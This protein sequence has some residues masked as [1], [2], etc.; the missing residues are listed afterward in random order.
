MAKYINPIDN[1]IFDVSIAPASYAAAETNAVGGASQVATA[2][3]G[4][5]FAT[6]QDVSAPFTFSSGSSRS[7]YVYY[8]FNINFIPQGAEILNVF[9]EVR[10]HTSVTV[11]VILGYFTKDYGID[12]RT[13]VNMS[14]SQNVPNNKN[15]TINIQTDSGWD[16][17]KLSR[18]NLRFG[19][20]TSG[21]MYF[22]GCTLTIRYQYNGIIYEVN[23]ENLSNLIGQIYPDGLTD[24]YPEDYIHPY[25][26]SMVGDSIT[27]ISVYD[28]AIDS[29]TDV[30]TLSDVTGQ[31]SEYI[32]TPG[33]SSTTNT[34]VDATAT[35]LVYISDGTTYEADNDHHYRDPI[36]KGSN[37]TS[38]LSSNKYLFRRSSQSFD[39]Y[40]DYKFD[41]SDI[42]FTAK[43]PDVSA[44]NLPNIIVSDVSVSVKGRAQFVSNY[45]SIANVRLYSGDG[46]PKSESIE[47]GSKTDQVV[48]FNYPGKWTVQE[49]QN[50][51]VRFTFGISGGYVVGITWKVNYIIEPDYP[52]YWTYTLP[53]VHEDHDITVVDKYQG[54]RYNV[55]TVVYYK[56]AVEVSNTHRVIRAND[57]YN[58]TIYTTDIAH[59]EL[60]DNNVNKT[61][62]LTR[63]SPN[64]NAYIYTI[65]SVTRNHTIKIVETLNFAISAESLVEDVTITLSSEKVYEGDSFTITLSTSSLDPIYIRDN[66]TNITNSFSRISSNTYRATISNVQ[67]DHEIIV[68]ERA[69]HV[70]TGLSNSENLVISPE[71]YVSVLDGDS[72]TL[73]ITTGNVNTMMMFNGN[74]TMITVPKY[75]VP[76]SNIIL[77][78]NDV[79]VSDQLMDV[80]TNKYSYT[81]SDVDES[82]TVV[83]YELFVPE[84]EDPQYNYYSLSIS[85][86][87]AVTNPPT[88][89]VRVV[90]GTNAN[91]SI[92]PQE[93]V[94]IICSDN[95]EDIT[96]KFQKTFI[97]GVAVEADPSY[98]VENR[99]SYKFILNNNTGYYTSN[100]TGISNSQAVARLNVVLPVDCTVELEYINYAEEGADFGI[101]GK[102]DIPLSADSGA[103][104]DQNA[105]IICNSAVY[106]KPYEQTIEYD[107]SAGSHFIDIKFLKN[108]NIYH[109]NNDSL[110]WK[111][112]SIKA[113]TPYVYYNYLVEDIHED[114]S[115]VFVFGENAY[116]TV[117]S[118]GINSRLFPNGTMIKRSDENYTLTIIPNIELFKLILRDNGIEKSNDIVKIEAV[119]D[120]Q[121]IVNYIYTIKRI[122]DNHV[123]EVDCK[124]PYD[125][126]QKLNGEW[127]SISKIYKKINGEWVLI[128]N[129]D[130][131]FINDPNTVRIFKG[132]LDNGR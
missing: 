25:V 38:S 102:I 50:A 126:F 31:L 57:T 89:T 65:D 123:I 51:F 101:F 40:I 55:D 60:I 7:Y 85:S 48:T 12:G 88:G 100:N 94:I 24:V 35:G 13:W 46:V 130:D 58:L 73:I 115:L 111:V 63:L 72:Q 43:I 117:E 98:T 99:A 82:H 42:L 104:V 11:P 18:I 95:G 9:G 116:Y 110:Q 33:L 108:S 93:P 74:P 75:A 77:K 107:V 112:K 118:S 19:Q 5:N 114:H 54:R 97:D 79:D 39:S 106:N 8:T 52:K 53:S 71:G 132:F 56:N 92:I 122:S 64:A 67:E 14:T 22:Y 128:Y 121:T 68:Y 84:Y 29:S 21:T 34:A 61:S 66:G 103:Q 23:T 41:F 2:V 30:H 105:Q 16:R 81:I 37:G 113:K 109:L 3:N 15:T 120:K 1:D 83:V 80:T 76:K 91:I 86:L 124:N 32:S 20:T 127:E 129:Y 119:I 125:V 44:N 70:I 45:T 62:L 36:G 131:I 4:F 27:D 47:F 59:T 87:N 96:D 17:D 6:N 26:F 78:D 10:A 28:D 90:E 49:L 69:K